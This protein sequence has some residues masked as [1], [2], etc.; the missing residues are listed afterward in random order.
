MKPELQISTLNGFIRNSFFGWLT[1]GVMSL[2]FSGMASAGSMVG[3]ECTS[4]FERPLSD[5]LDVQ[6]TSG[7]SFFPPVPDYVGWAGGDFVY[8]ALVD[9]AGLAN[10]AIVQE[11]GT[12]LGTEFSG[13]ILECALSN[14][15]ARIS[16]VLETRNAMGFAQS[17]QDLSDNGFDFAGTDTIF[18]NKAVDIVNGAQ[19]ALGPST[20]RAS[21][22][23][24]SS[25]APLPDFL[26]VVNDSETYGPYTFD[27]R[28]T[29]VGR[30]PDGTKA[31]LRVQQVCSAEKGGEQTCSR[32]IVDL[33]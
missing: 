25:G 19:A 27:F 28:S 29:T 2:V 3:S 10:E 20:L 17:I 4:I 15:T 9:Y 8:F 6:G 16:V 26:A 13:R 5:F 32:E 14:G 30:R 33:N 31:R 23:N 11:G 1:V 22:I 24:S 7:S 18:G 21:F 12:S